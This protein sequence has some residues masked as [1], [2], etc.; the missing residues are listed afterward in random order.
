MRLKQ[1]S[2][3]TSSSLPKISEILPAIHLQRFRVSG[4][5]QARQAG[6]EL[7]GLLHDLQVDFLH[8]NL[9]TELWRELGALQELGVNAGR[10]GG[11]QLAGVCE[12]GGRTL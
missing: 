3:T 5:R 11:Q 10:H 12:C 1:S 4:G 6:G 7:D 2:I 9:L 8:V